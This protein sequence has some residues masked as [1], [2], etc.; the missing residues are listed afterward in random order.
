ML[1]MMMMMLQQLRKAMVLERWSERHA[2]KLEVPPCAAQMHVAGEMMLT[3]AAW[4]SPSLSV[5]A[6]SVKTLRRLKMLVQVS[7]PLTRK[8]LWRSQVEMK[9][10]TA[11]A[12][13][14][15]SQQQ[16]C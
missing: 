6:R 5:K 4:R 15:T 2:A 16:H 13:E 9:H 8:Q 3:I 1:T 10:A 14:W 12:A 11:C 7:T